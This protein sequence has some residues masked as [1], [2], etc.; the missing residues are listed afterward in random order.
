MEDHENFG[1]FHAKLIDIVNSSFNLGE[2]LI[3]NSKVARNILRS[4]PKKFRAIVTTIEES[5]NVD[6]LKIDE[7]VGSLQTFEMTLASPRKS[8]G[9][10]LNAIKE[11]SLG[12]KGEGGKKMSGGEVAR[13]TRKFKKYMTFKKYK[14]NTRKMLKMEKSN[15]KTKWKGQKER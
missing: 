15:R 11:E 2:V 1:E 14:S 5:K 10:A 13:F 7:L 9:I 12:S 3:S 8:K 6:S 4:L